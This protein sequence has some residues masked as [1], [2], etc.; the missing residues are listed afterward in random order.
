M[1]ILLGPPATPRSLAV[2]DVLA[3]VARYPRLRYMGSKYQVIP[4]LVDVFAGLDFDTAI[5]PFS[6]S[7]V[8]AYALKAMG[9]SVTT[10][11]Y[12]NF[13]ATV[14]RATVENPGVQLTPA[15]IDALTGLPA[16]D[17]DFIR[18]T[19]SGL[20][21]PDEDH[22]FLDSAWSHIDHL[23]GYKRDLAIAALCLAA[24]RKQPR[25]V[26]TV[27]DFRYD[28]GRKALRLPLRDQ[29]RLAADAFNAVA[30]DTG[31]TN[32]ALVGDV[33]NINPSGYDLAYFDPPYAPPRD[34]NDYI[35]RY[36]FLEGLSLYWRGQEIMYDTK[37]RKIAKR[38]TPYAYRHTIHKAL[39]DLFDQFRHSTLVVSYGSNSIPDEHELLALLRR[40][41]TQVD[42]FAVPHR[43]S[44]GT[45]STALR[46]EVH[47]YIFVAR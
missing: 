45:H 29:F 6:G 28:D 26:F 46:R 24:A 38:F 35:K 19:Y 31:R 13:P 42:V 32:L 37:T 4:H 21:F 2:Q 43:Y 22:A 11:D 41:K 15:D 27:T 12:L 47:E 8:V 7:G 33:A 23:P 25:G 14:A 39:A 9:K 40:V 20:Y 10:S 3:Q 17:R 5:D 36:H 18:R 1:A 34:D 44:F 16:D 30:L